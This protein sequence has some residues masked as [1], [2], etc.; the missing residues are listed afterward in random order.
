MQMT[1]RHATYYR[2]HKNKMQCEC[3]KWKTE[4]ISRVQCYNKWYR[5][6]KKGLTD[7][8][9]EDVAKE[10]GYT[11][12]SVG[13]ISNHRK[14]HVS[15][16]GVVGKLCSACK[17]WKPLEEYNNNK[18][19]WDKKRTTCKQC[20]SEKRKHSRVR[21]RKYMHKYEIERK[22]NDPYF[23]FVKRMRSRINS[24]VRHFAMV[25]SDSTT[26]LLG[27]S[28]KEVR[29]HIEKQFKNGMTWDN[30]SRWHIDH[31]IPF[32]AF[33]NDMTPLNQKIVCWYMNLQPLWKEDNL[34]KGGSYKEE[35]KLKLIQLYKQSHNL[36]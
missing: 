2:K 23:A 16:N 31:I 25:K 18:S 8:S 35:D 9:W 19:S 28:I 1:T 36:S 12:R 29:T 34:S 14:L 27:A 21:I 30:A 20:L 11:N 6:H 4:N 17:Q 15:R 7:K 32:S 13:K 5:D 26:T 24:A 22:K 33:K 3:K 10:M